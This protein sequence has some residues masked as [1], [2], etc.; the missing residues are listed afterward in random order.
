MA[1]DHNQP[2][3]TSIRKEVLPGVTVTTGVV[4]VV[5]RGVVVAKGVVVVRGTIVVVVVVVGVG[6]C[7]QLQAV[8]M[9][10]LAI[11][12]RTCGHPAGNVL[13][14]GCTPRLTGPPHCLPV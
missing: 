11:V 2:R 3:S 7:R 10:A 8:A 6:R 4:V 9:Y 14:A 5:A 12:L 13:V 1:L